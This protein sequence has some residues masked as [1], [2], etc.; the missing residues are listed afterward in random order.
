MTN[1]TT[2]PKTTVDGVIPGPYKYSD[3]GQQVRTA[4]D[5]TTVCD[6]RGF[7][8]LTAQHGHNSPV[9]VA[10]I[11]D[12]TGVMLAASWD[13]AIALKDAVSLIAHLGGNPKFQVKALEKAGIKDGKG[14]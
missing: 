4:D 3:A 7:G 8:W 1:S 5:Q 14:V 13:M 11:Q 9:K 2:N 10:A 12:A 6:I